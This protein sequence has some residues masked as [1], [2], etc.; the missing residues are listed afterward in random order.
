MSGGQWLSW[1]GMTSKTRRFSLGPH[2]G[3]VFS[4]R[5]RIFRCDTTSSTQS[6]STQFPG[7]NE[8]RPVEA[9]HLD[10]Y[11]GRYLRPRNEPCRKPVSFRFEGQATALL[12]QVWHIIFSRKDDLSTR[13]AISQVDQDL[14]SFLKE[15]LELCQGVR[16]LCC[17]AVAVVLR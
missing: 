7:A 8:T 16:G 10:D 11:N 14:W 1:R 5:L 12:D 6:L 17:G 9:E 4:H 13:T 15:L 3:A 2:D